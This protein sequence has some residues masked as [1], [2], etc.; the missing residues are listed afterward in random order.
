MTSNALLIANRPPARRGVLGTRRAACVTDLGQT[1]IVAVL[2]V[3]LIIGI[4]GAHPGGHRR[5]VGTAP[6]ADARSP[7]SPAGPSRPGE[8][9]YVTAINTNPSLAQCSTGTN[10][11]ATCSGIDYGEWNPVR[12]SSAHQRRRRVLRLRQPPAHLR[13]HHPCPDQPVGPGGRCRPQHVDTTNNYLFDTETINLASTNGFLTHVWWSNYES[14]NQTGDY[15]GLQLQLAER[16]LRRQQRSRRL[17]AGLL[18]VRTTTCSVRPT[19]TTPCSSG[20]SAVASPTF[21][22]GSSHPEGAVHRR[23]RRPELPLRRLQQRR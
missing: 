6:G 23:D 11:S 13:P 15:S 21:G 17:R 14:Y 8:N 20:N 22:N 7:S 2:A 5:P 19:P 4:I 9:A 12:S 18:R 10:D 16:Q 1:A 3:T